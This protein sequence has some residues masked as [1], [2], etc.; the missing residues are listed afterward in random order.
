MSTLSWIDFDETE[1][2][3]VRGILA[4]FEEKEAR[5][6][7]GLGPIRDSIADHLFPGTST[8]QTRLRYMFFIPWVYMMVEDIDGEP[9][10]LVEAAK[11]LEIR[12]IDSLRS[13]GEEEGVIGR[14]A[15][16][17]L[18]RLPSSIYWSGLKSWGIRKFPGSQEAYFASLPSLRRQ[19]HRSKAAD[20]SSV[21]GGF[22]EDLWSPGLLGKPS[23]LLQR[24]DFRLTRDEAGFLIDRLVNSQPDSLLAH[25]ARSPRQVECEFVW[26]HPDFSAFPPAAKRLVEH[27]QV[28]SA[29]LHGASLLYNLMLAECCDN[30]DWVERYRAELSR[31][32]TDEFDLTAAS[33]WS[34]P[35]FW[36]CIKHENHR[37]QYRTRSFVE[38]WRELAHEKS[39]EV[40]D[41]ESARELVREREKGLK[42][43]QSRFVNHAVLAQWG[44]RSGADRLNFRWREAN[45]HVRDLADAT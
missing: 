6:E 2:Q 30:E 45:R 26:T 9:H 38:Q 21:T 32:K 41:L 29:V 34:P 1:R 4:L 13:G 20:H 19:R 22:D 39:G 37:V 36:E 16:A 15:G 5:D 27:A 17:S 3:R 7:L 33:D 24:A 40:A 28:F 42:R 8:L 44:G 14:T 18:K 31:W 25:L 43:S 23:D 35:E 10:E 11:S 12:L